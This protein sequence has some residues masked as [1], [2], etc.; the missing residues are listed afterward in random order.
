MRYHMLT[1]ELIRASGEKA[2]V[3]GHSYVGTIHILLALLDQPG[4]I[5]TM[6]RL[7][8]LEPEVVSAMA[9]LLYGAG[10][11]DLPLPQGFTPRAKEVFRLSAQ[12]ARNRC[13]REIQPIHILM[14]LARAIRI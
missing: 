8:G 4:Q 1:N 5:G 2:R 6:L 13:A 7:L 14:A 10:T 3:L 9:Q 11:P 12:E